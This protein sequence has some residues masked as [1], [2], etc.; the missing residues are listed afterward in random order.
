MKTY[1]KIIITVIIT[2]IITF[3]ATSSL[4]IFGLNFLPGQLSDSDELILKIAQIK[5]HIKNDYLY[6]DVDYEKANDFAI[7]GYIESL[8]EPYTHYYTRDEFSSYMGGIEESYVGIGVTVSV[9]TEHD[10]IIV[11]SPTKDSPAYCA[12]IKAGDYIL[13]VDGEYFTAN[14]MDACVSKIKNGAEN[15]DVVLTIE[16]EG[17]VKDY[18]VTRKEIIGNS[19]SYEML[20]DKIGYISISGFKTNGDGSDESTYSE[21]VAAVEALNSKGM[22]KLII[23]VR[24]NPGGVMGEV[25]QIADYI[26]PEGIITYTESKTGKR[27]EYKSDSKELNIPMSILINSSSAS[28]SEILTGALKDYERATVIGTKSFGKGIVQNLFTFPDGSGMTM[29]VS[30]YFTPNGTSIHGVGIEPNITVELP[31]EYKGSYVSEI[32]RNKDT[33]LN[34]AIEVLKNK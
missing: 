32:P 13:A 26:L 12:G 31:E 27:N 3:F 24:D 25:C 4:F 16:R 34:K 10:K 18:T 17:S 5:Q 23:D 28:A 8:E 6:N 9:D 22:E 15:T 7:K 19:V 14:G 2:M 20:D 29:T 30:K 21:F 1:I 11:I 33:Q